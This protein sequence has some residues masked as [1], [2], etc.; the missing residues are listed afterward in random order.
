MSVNSKYLHDKIFDPRIPSGILKDAGYDTISDDIAMSADF[1]DVHNQIILNLIDNKDKYTNSDGSINYDLLLT[2]C[3]GIAAKVDHEHFDS[4]ACLEYKDD[5]IK[6]IKTVYKSV[7]DASV[8]AASSDT[9][10]FVTTYNNLRKEFNIDKDS[11][12]RDANLFLKLESTY[13]G[14]DKENMRKMEIEVDKAIVS[15]PI[16]DSIKVELLNS[17]SVISNS[18]LLWR[19]VDE[20]KE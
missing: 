13:G 8:S 7:E 17:N 6:I 16:S 18:T 10:M 14:L 9:T 1:G 5:I 4:T 3:A 2:D 20:F 12:N 11:Y 15:S 19:T